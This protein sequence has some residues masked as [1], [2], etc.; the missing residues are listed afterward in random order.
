[1]LCLVTSVFCVFFLWMKSRQTCRFLCPAAPRQHPWHSLSALHIPEE[2][3]STA[4]G[5]AISRAGAGTAE[6]CGGRGAGRSPRRNLARPA[7]ARPGP[8]AAN[9]RPEEAEP[10][11]EPG[12]TSNPTF[13]PWRESSATNACP[14]AALPANPS[15]PGGPSDSPGF[16][17]QLTPFPQEGKRRVGGR[18]WRPSPSV[19]ASRGGGRRAAAARRGSMRRPW[20]A[21]PPSD[22][23]CCGRR[24]CSPSAPPP[25]AAPGCE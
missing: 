15:S 5:L 12:K 11:T 25:P 24:C 17:R 20:G 4:E 19:P 13:S 14:P 1:M 22:R 16:P 3:G 7:P 2:W 6:R 21:G 23:A 10:G 8:R 9:A 18:H